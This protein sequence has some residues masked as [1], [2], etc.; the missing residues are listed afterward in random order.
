MKSMGMPVPGL[1]AAGPVR[2]G[3][4]DEAARAARSGA[5]GVGDR[6][7]IHF[8]NR[9]RNIHPVYLGLPCTNCHVD[10]EYAADYPLP[11]KVEGVPG[12]APGVVDRSTCLGCHKEGGVATTFRVPRRGAGHGAGSRLGRDG[13]GM[14]AS[15]VQSRRSRPRASLCGPRVCGP[16]AGPGPAL[17]L[18]GGSRQAPVLWPPPGL[19]AHSVQALRAC[20]RCIA[21]CPTGP[22]A[23]RAAASR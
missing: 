17:R 21:V 3:V 5:A 14:S 6:Y 4:I 2:T 1:L 15:A 7:A 16:R 9:F 12:G 18:A 8:G 19:C 20:Q 10:P 22:S 23:P 13:P 11:R